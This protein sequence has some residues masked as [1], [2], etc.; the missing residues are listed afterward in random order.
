MTLSIADQT[1]IVGVGWSAFSKASGVSVLE[2]ATEAGLAALTDAGLSVAD[3]DGVISYQYNYPDTIYP[4]DLSHAL[5]IE[6]CNFQILDTHGGASACSMV[7]AAAMAVHAGM[8]NNVLVFRAMNGRSARRTGGSRQ[9]EGS[10]QWLIPFGSAHAAASFGPY[11]TAYMDRYGATTLDLAHVAVTQRANAALNTKAMMRTPIT[12]DDHQNS[13]WVCYPFRLLDCCLQSDGAVALVVT[14]AE[15]ARSLRQPPVYISGMIGGTYPPM[16]VASWEIEARRVAPLL[17]ERSGL[18]P[19]DVD[20]AELYD[21]F[22]GMVMLHVE[23]FGL[24]APGEAPALYRSGGATLDGRLPVNTHGGLL[25]EVYMNGLNHVVEAVQQLRPGGVVDDLCTG[26]HDYDRTHC[27]QLRDPQI[28]L[29]CG[30]CGASSL[31]LRRA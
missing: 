14:S 31:L 2:L 28:G 20:F 9:P 7:A 6:G 29:V 10:G 5:G 8:C 4:R 16:P 22:T 12:V 17:Y 23:G 26:P 1:A 25:S 13:P 30:E 15:R 18:T 3:V 19:A 27:R 21:P 11:Y 24:A